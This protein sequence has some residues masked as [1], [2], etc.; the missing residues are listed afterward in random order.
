MIYKS[1]LV[2]QC[3]INQLKTRTAMSP[4]TSVQLDVIKFVDNIFNNPRIKHGRKR[5]FNFFLCCPCKDTTKQETGTRIEHP[6]FMG[7]QNSGTN[8]AAEA[9]TTHPPDALMMQTAEHP[10]VWFP[11]RQ[12]LL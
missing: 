10:S 7:L 4:A 6:F 8:S 1:F 9:S 11:H 5:M 3:H 2:L 12:N